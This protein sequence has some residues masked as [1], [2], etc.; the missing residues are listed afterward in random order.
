MAYMVYQQYLTA[1]KEAY[2]GSPDV[3]LLA[4]EA[5]SYREWLEALEINPHIRAVLVEQARALENAFNDLL[6][7]QESVQEGN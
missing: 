2:A 6:V 3:F 7:R 5:Q 1:V 4:A